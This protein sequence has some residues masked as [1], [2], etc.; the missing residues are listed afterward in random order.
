MMEFQILNESRNNSI[1]D[2]D[3]GFAFYGND[4]TVSNPFYG[5]V[6]SQAG[7][8]TQY[9]RG[10]ARE[11]GTYKQII[12][13]NDPDPM[14]ATIEFPVGDDIPCRTVGEI[15]EYRVT[16]NSPGNYSLTGSNWGTA[17][18]P[19]L[20][21]PKALT[22]TIA[23]SNKLYDDFYIRY[24]GIQPLTFRATLNGVD[25]ANKFA[26]TN[27]DFDYVRLNLNDGNNTLIFNVTKTNGTALTYTFNYTV[28]CQK[29]TDNDKVCDA[30]DNCPRD[31]NQKQLDADNDGRGDVCDSTPGCG[32]CSLPPC[33]DGQII[34]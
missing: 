26:P 11:V 22:N 8:N 4:G 3:E 28:T 27:G 31:A 33:D 21:F 7:G 1:G 14:R 13:V 5:V 19:A 29:D 30:I 10:V 25:I 34:P 2:K 20:S 12:T 17:N 18:D 15:H 16:Y 6:T 24:L 23:I 32:G 9:V